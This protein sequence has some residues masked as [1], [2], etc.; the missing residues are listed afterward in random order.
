VTI[1]GLVNDVEYTCTVV[2]RNAVG[3]GPAVSA[4]PVRPLAGVPGAPTAVQAEG[5]DGSVTVRWSEPG[6]GGAPVVGYRV[7]ATGPSESTTTEV[8]AQTTATVGGLTN[9]TP[10]DVSVRAL[11]PSG[12]HGP[13]G[14][15]SGPVIP[16]GPPGAPQAVAVSARSRALDVRWRPAADNGSPLTGH[17]VHAEPGGHRRDLP[18]AAE[19][20]LL[21]GLEND[22]EYVITV[23]ALNHRG[24]GPSSVP[25]PARPSRPE[26]LNLEIKSPGAG[27][28]QVDWKGETPAPVGCGFLVQ[29]GGTT[30]LHMSDCLP[31]GLNLRY[32][33][34]AYG[35]YSIT[36]IARW[37]GGETRRGPVV[38]EAVEPSP[39]QLTLS[40]NDFPRD[41]FSGWVEEG[42]L[43]ADVQESGLWTYR[44]DRVDHAMEQILRSSNPDTGAHWYGRLNGPAAPLGYHWDVDIGYIY[45]DP[46]PDRGP[47]VHRFLREDREGP[48][49]GLDCYLGPTPPPNDPDGWTDD[50]LLG[51][52]ALP[53]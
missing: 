9:G 50:G 21:D 19:S 48:D 37:V 30:R 28:F 16:T 26:I 47:P 32:P 41:W 23:V 4:L 8:A 39:E 46:G 29:G 2:A 40:M 7:I 1:Q 10:Y 43:Y 11:A 27:K 12:A 42:N 49:R 22:I 5:G 36:A 52:S 44:F 53:R 51:F 6:A 14:L 34:T 17:V 15:A 24:P 20:V 33:I 45:R 13:S 35:T 25:K 18:G 3:P 38:V 31:S